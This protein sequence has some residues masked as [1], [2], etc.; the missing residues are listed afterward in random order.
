MT[1]RE[2]EHRRPDIVVFKRVPR[3][4]QLIDVE[5][6]GDQNIALKEVEETAHYSEFT[7]GGG[8]KDVEATCL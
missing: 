6:H 8:C 4:R 1:D 2:I 7:E 5:I 3:E